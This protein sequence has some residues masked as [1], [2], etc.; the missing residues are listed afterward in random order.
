MSQQNISPTWYRLQDPISNEWIAVNASA[1]T[2]SFEKTQNHHKFSFIFALY[3]EYKRPCFYIFSHE[4]NKFL[5]ITEASRQITAT[6]D[7]VSEADSFSFDVQSGGT[8]TL[9]ANSDDPWTTGEDEDP[10][11]LGTD[12]TANVAKT[13]ISFVPSTP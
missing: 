6:E 5:V 7:C 4:V 3:D 2:L 12:S 11:V 13:L 8:W 1:L 9:A 10:I